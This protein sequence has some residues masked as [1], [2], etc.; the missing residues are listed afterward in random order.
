MNPRLSYRVAR[1]LLVLLVV[2]PG[3]LSAEVATTAPR[4]GGP[5]VITSTSI[6]TGG[7]GLAGGSYRMDAS[8]GQPDTAR[9]DSARYRVQ[10]GFWV[11]ASSASAE[12]FGN[13]FE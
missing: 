1:P 13:G 6:D 4:V 8:T 11:D 10:G 5:Y 7:G 2:A 12:L 3:V 9:L